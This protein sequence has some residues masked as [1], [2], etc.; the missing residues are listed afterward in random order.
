MLLQGRDVTGVP[1][2]DQDVNTRL[3]GLRAVPHMSVGDNVAYGL[4][5]RKVPSAS[6]RNAS[7]CAAHGQAGGV[8]GSALGA[9]LSGGQ[10]QR[11]ALARALVN[12]PSVL[13]LD[14]PLGSP[15]PEGFARKCR[16][17]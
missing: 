8:R 6:A 7:R 5:V 1:P 11:V 2:F 4:V 16:S 14:E 13:L 3:P 17:S 15:G 12:R 10:R 9:R